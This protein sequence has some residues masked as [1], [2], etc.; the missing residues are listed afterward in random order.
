[1]TTLKEII[2]H[3][4]LL[5]ALKMHIK[6]CL[7]LSVLIKAFH[8]HCN[9]VNYEKVTK[10]FDNVIEENK[11]ILKLQNVSDVQNSRS[12]K[13]QIDDKIVGGTFVTNGEFPWIVGIWR[14][15]SS[16]PFCGGSLLNNRYLLKN[17]YFR[18]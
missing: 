1:M 8:I 14:L 15:K 17:R 2:S 18:P 11:D 12:S 5:K 16:R 6:Q 7:I 10:K 9:Q 4:C 13:I 3:L